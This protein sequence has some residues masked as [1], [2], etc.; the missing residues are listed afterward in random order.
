M[1]GILI[2]SGIYIFV[3]E[4]TSLDISQKKMTGRRFQSLPTSGN[5][6]G[7]AILGR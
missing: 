3:P 6:A 1:P 5:D 2:L 4:E 7:C